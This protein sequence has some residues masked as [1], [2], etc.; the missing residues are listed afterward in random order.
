MRP[1]CLFGLMALL[2][3]GGALF[4]SC[5][6]P[7]AYTTGSSRLMR[8]RTWSTTLTKRKCGD[9]EPHVN[10]DQSLLGHRGATP[11]VHRDYAQIKLIGPAYNN[12]KLVN[13]VVGL[14]SVSLAKT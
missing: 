9:C 1:Y 8:R 11:I 12:I 7:S 2:L 5:T 10:R 14:Q 3:V 6:A 13:D 4:A